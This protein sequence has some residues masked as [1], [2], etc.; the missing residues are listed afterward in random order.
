MQRFTGAEEDPV[1]ACDH[2]NPLRPL[3]FFR[4]NDG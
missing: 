3:L 1:L 4:Q 2:L